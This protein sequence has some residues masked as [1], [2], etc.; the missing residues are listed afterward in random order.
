MPNTVNMTLRWC[1]WSF[2]L[3]RFLAGGEKKKKRPAGAITLVVSCQ[4]RNRQVHGYALDPSYLVWRPLPPSRYNSKKRPKDV[5]GWGTHWLLHLNCRIAFKGSDFFHQCP[6]VL[7]FGFLS[8]PS[9]NRPCICQ[10]YR[11]WLRCFVAH[12]EPRVRTR[13]CTMRWSLLCVLEVGWYLACWPDLPRSSSAL[14][15]VFKAWGQ[16]P[17]SNFPNS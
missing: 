6:V 1:S 12:Q 4:F 10:L 3:L 13:P 17:K 5:T 15:V 2:K 7:T 14:A 8:A 16:K 11:R 9:Y